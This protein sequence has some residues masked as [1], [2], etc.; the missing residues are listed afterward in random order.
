MWI[1]TVDL[2]IIGTVFSSASEG[3][4]GSNFEVANLL[5]KCTMNLG[6]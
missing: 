4:L 1:C 5:G 2:V 3:C 6:R